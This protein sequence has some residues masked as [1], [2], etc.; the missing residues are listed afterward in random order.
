M[1]GGDHNDAFQKGG[2]DYVARLLAFIERSLARRGLSVY[3]LEEEVANV[4][5]AAVPHGA[6]AASAAAPIDASIG[7]DGAALLPAA[8]LGAGPDLAAALLPAPR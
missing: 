3:A 2:D 5:D 8:L 1:Q 7:A 4:G 6:R